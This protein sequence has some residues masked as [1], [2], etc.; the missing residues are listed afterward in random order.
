MLKIILVDDHNLFRESLRRLIEA[1]S[2]GEVIAE[3][4][5]GKEL[6]DYLKVIKTP[7]DIVLMDI[8][9]PIMDGMDAT[10][11][12]LELFPS[13]KILVLSMFGDERYYQRMVSLGVKGFV[14]KNS[15]IKELKA[16]IEE[17]SIGGN[18]FSNELL[19][20]I[21]ISLSNKNRHINLSDREIE[22]LRLICQGLSNKEIACKLHLSVDTIKWHR[23]NILSK[24]G[25]RN[26]VSLA[27]YSIREKLVEI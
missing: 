19:K 10:R 25:C 7:P 27:V 20:R 9:M 24:T 22:I 18:W 4:N 8:A 6:I 23:T 14:L 11:A 13:I 2:I 21:I 17:V 1:E 16:A 3:A 12:A 5:N 26:S 15:S